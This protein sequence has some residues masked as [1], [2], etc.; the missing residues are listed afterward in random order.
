MARQYLSKWLFWREF[1]QFYL[2][3]KMNKSSTYLNQSTSSSCRLVL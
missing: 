2:S 3:F 1:L